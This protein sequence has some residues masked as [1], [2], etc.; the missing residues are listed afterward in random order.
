MTTAVKKR[1]QKQRKSKSSK[2]NV[3]SRK[4]SKFMTKYEYT[5]LIGDR[6][7]MLSDGDECLLEDREECYDVVE[8]A[9][10]EIREKP[11]QFPL[12]VVRHFRNG[13]IEVWPVDEMVI[14]D[15]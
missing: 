11:S 5:K 8:L 3:T 14:V 2:S 1:S 13:G 7:K 4:T 6:A 9:K 15:H 10:R 12:V